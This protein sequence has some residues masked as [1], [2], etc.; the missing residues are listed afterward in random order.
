M[1]GRNYLHIYLWPLLPLTQLRHCPDVNWK[2]AQIF[3]QFCY[4]SRSGSAELKTFQ[5]FL[6]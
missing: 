5:H 1:C 6:S 3:G 2:N 4:M